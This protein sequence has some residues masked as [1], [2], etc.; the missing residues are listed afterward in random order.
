[1]CLLFVEGMIEWI[2]V[3]EDCEDVLSILKELRIQTNKIT[4]QSFLEYKNTS[5][6]WYSIYC[7]LSYLSGLLSNTA[8]IALH[9]HKVQ[10]CPLPDLILAPA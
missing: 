4:T 2:G 10:L 1:M 5:K 6:W 7:L 9:T 3:E 8:L